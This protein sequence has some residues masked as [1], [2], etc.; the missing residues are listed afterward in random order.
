MS[1]K[2][3]LDQTQLRELQDLKGSDP[4]LVP[5]ELW[6]MHVEGNERIDKADFPRKAN[7]YSYVITEREWFTNIIQSLKYLYIENKRLTTNEGGVWLTCKLE[8]KKAMPK[9][10]IFDASHRVKG[11]FRSNG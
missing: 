6:N 4:L 8:P 9:V 10:D 7:F 2:L 3:N 5:I 1:L 11:S